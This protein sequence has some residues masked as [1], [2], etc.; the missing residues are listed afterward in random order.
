MFSRKISHQQGYKKIEFI[1]FIS[2]IFPKIG[3]IFFSAFLRIYQ[4]SRPERSRNKI[5]WEPREGAERASR[6]VYSIKVFPHL[7]PGI[8]GILQMPHI[9]RIPAI[10]APPVTRQRR[11]NQ[12]AHEDFRN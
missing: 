8:A 5:R 3:A 6:L 2:K 4:S 12:E 11:R 9:A 1:P 10:P 7:I